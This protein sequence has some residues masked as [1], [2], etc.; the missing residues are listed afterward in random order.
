ML[1]S[2]LLEG[3]FHW[4]DPPGDSLGTR[5]VIPRQRNTSR[6]LAGE[7]TIF[8]TLDWTPWWCSDLRCMVV[9]CVFVGQRN[10]PASQGC[11]H[12]CLGS[13]FIGL[14]NYHPSFAARSWGLRCFLL[15]MQWAPHSQVPMAMPQ[16]AGYPQMAATE[17][18]HGVGPTGAQCAPEL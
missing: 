4:G 10:S 13:S 15:A 6:K 5:M 16:M 14:G 17:T 2:R 18:A 8:R 9:V 12:F 7:H 3:D 1:G 11:S